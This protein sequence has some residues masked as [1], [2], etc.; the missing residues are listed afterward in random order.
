M[1]P[2]EFP[3]YPSSSVET[4]VF[5]HG[6]L[7]QFGRGGTSCSGHP[8]SLAQMADRQ[9]ENLSLMV[10]VHSKQHSFGQMQIIP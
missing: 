6:V 10:W 2:V 9:V 7:D 4:L 8:Q 3:I 5:H 1:A